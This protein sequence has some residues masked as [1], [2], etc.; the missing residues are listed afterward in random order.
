M[1]FHH[2]AEIDIYKDEQKAEHFRKIGEQA[3][4]RQ[5]YD[6]LKVAIYG[7]HALLPDEER[8]GDPMTGTGV[9]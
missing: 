5:N 3:L 4:T 9:G 6:E 2:F 8:L 1:L 7:L